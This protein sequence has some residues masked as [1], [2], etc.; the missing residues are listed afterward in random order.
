MYDLVEIGLI[1]F[2]AL[3][4]GRIAGCLLCKYCDC[5]KKDDETPST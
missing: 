4:V 3:L 1:I 5:N 2:G